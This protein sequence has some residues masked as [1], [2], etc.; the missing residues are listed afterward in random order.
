MLEFFTKSTNRIVTVTLEL[1]GNTVVTPDK[2]LYCGSSALAINGIYKMLHTKTTEQKNKKSRQQNFVVFE[3][4]TTTN[5]RFFKN[6]FRKF[7][8]FCQD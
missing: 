6:Q 8:I 1:V 2:P 5:K 7:T 4:T 3:K